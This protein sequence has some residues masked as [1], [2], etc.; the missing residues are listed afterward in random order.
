MR[1]AIVLCTE[2]NNTKLLTIAKSMEQG[3]NK[4]SH[5][6]DVI[7]CKNDVGKKLHQYDFIVVM[8]DVE[9]F[10]PKKLPNNF[11]YFFDS[12]G[13]FNSKK[14]LAV[15]LKRSLFSEKALKVLMAGMENF[16]LTV[17]DQIVL[18]SSGFAKNFASSYTL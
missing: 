6:V 9:G 1:I 11:K 10:I 12:A 3:F 8:S 18:P 13:T 17:Y 16:G 14:A 2:S 5:F 4:T 7:N 15:V